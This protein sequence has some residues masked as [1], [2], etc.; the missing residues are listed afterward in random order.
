MP[1]TQS[2]AAHTRRNARRTRAEW[3]EAREK[4]KAGDSEP[5]MSDSLAKAAF[6]S[7]LGGAIWAAEQFATLPGVQRVIEAV[8]GMLGG[9]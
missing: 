1:R 7:L 3:A 8:K 4:A 9:G 6:A 5:V 2:P